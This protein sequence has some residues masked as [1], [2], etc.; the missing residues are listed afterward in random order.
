MSDVMYLG[1]HKSHDSEPLPSTREGEM[2]FVA[3]EERFTRKKLQAC[4]HKAKEY[5]LDH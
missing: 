4:P 1:F 5:M 3:N 2:L